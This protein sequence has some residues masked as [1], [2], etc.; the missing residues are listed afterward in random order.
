MHLTNLSATAS[1]SAVL[2]AVQ[3]EQVRLLSRDHTTL[4][5][6]VARGKMLT[7]EVRSAASFLKGLSCQFIVDAEFDEFNVNIVT[8]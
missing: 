2:H 5:N 8:H 6:M 3:K 4:C 7:D 1:I